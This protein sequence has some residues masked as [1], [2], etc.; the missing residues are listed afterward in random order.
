MPQRDQVGTLRAASNTHKTIIKE[1]TYGTYGINIINDTNPDFK[2]PFG[3]A[4]GLYDND[5][6]CETQDTK[7]NEEY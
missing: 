4:G 2:V 1:I 7:N 5:S 3:F 6:K